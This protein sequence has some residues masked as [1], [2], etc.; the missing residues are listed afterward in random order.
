MLEHSVDNVCKIDNKQNIKPTIKVPD[1]YSGLLETLE[2]HHQLSLCRVTK[3]VG[4]SI[5]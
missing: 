5:K 1:H 3:L 4:K 2:K